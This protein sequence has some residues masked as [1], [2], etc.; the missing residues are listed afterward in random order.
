MSAARFFQGLV[1]HVC[2]LKGLQS[3]PNP[4]KT[5]TGAQLGWERAGV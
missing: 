4:K 2:M 3:S 1:K 5:L